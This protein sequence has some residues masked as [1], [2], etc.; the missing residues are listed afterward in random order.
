MVFYNNLRC[1]L[2]CFCSLLWG[3]NHHPNRKADNQRWKYPLWL[4]HVSQACHEVPRE[5]RIQSMFTF[6]NVLVRQWWEKKILLNC[7][8]SEI[9]N[10]IFSVS[11]SQPSWFPV[12][13]AWLF[14]T[15]GGKQKCQCLTGGKRNCS[16]AAALRGWQDSWEIF[17][18]FLLLTTF[19]AVCVS[20]NAF[21]KCRILSI[22]GSNPS[23]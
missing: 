4:L 11:L 14:F 8:D 6:C 20:L 12:M 15:E 17:M 23:N 13:V 1:S 7:F 22:T 21:R 18:P 9:V 3:G 2:K 10:F 19:R 16:E 5:G